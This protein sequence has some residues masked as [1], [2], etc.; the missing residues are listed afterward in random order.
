MH[1]TY[2]H[3]K[4][5]ARAYDQVYYEGWEIGNLPLCGKKI[6]DQSAAVYKGGIRPDRTP[7]F[8]TSAD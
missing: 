7:S 6:A 2:G 8:N 1:P 3:P 4:S 5:L